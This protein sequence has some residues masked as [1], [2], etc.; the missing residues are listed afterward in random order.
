MAAL[1]QSRLRDLDADAG[2]TGS[3]K[4]VCL[5]SCAQVD[6]AMLF[7]PGHVLQYHERAHIDHLFT[8][9]FFTCRRFSC[10]TSCSSL[11]APCTAIAVAGKITVINHCNMC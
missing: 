10:I 3:R 2:M 1:Q 4:S 8:C 9:D 6:Y 5:S 11:L 7:A